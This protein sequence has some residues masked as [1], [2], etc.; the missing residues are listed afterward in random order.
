MRPA[1]SSV[2]RR[3]KVASSARAAG[4]IPTYREAVAFTDDHSPAKRA[5]ALRRP[6]TSPEYPLQMG[7]ALD[8][9]IQGRLAGDPEFLEYLRTSA[10]GH[11]PWDQ[12]FREVLLGPW[13]NPER[14]RADRF[15][16][17]RLNS[18][19]DLTNDTA[20][21]FFGVNV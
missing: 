9:V 11:K 6:L 21:A 17:R 14:K 3:R 10:A 7:R 12:V 5:R 13:D 2:R 20:R 8:E 4:R 15:L 18:L 1:R 16:A 19:D